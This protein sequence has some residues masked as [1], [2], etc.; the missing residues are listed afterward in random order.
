MSAATKYPL[1]GYRPGDLIMGQQLGKNICA[2]DIL[3]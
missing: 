1:Y 2:A 3:D